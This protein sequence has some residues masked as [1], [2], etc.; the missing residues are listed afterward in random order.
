MK[1]LAPTE[2]GELHQGQ[3]QRQSK[4]T[5]VSL[6]KCGRQLRMGSSEG[7]TPSFPELIRAIDSDL[8][9]PICLINRDDEDRDQ[10]LRHISLI[11]LEVNDWFGAGLRPDQIGMMAKRVITSYPHLYLDDLYIFKD[12]CLSLQYGKVFGQFTPS[13]FFE[14]LSTYWQ[15]RSTE[16]ENNAIAEHNETKGQREYT[17]KEWF[18]MAK[19]KTME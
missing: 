9:A 10:L 6:L 16:I 8:I 4:K 5:S 15:D 3:L 7:N 18:Q 14:W 12:K 1:S 17:P 13:V 19:R 2:Q 11:I